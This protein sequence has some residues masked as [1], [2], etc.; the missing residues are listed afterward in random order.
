MSRFKFASQGCRVRS[1]PGLKLANAFGVTLGCRKLEPKA[2]ISQHFGV[3]LGCREL[4]A[5]AG[6]ANAFGVFVCKS[7]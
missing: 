4:E 3:T 6:I 2:G 1:T 5:K 7:N